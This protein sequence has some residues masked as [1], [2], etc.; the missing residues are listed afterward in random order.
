MSRSSGPT[1]S[2]VLRLLLTPRPRSGI[3]QSLQSH[4]DTDEVSR[5]KFDRLPRTAAGYTPNALDGYGLCGNPHARPAFRASY[6]VFVHRLARLLH[7]SFRP[8]LA[9]TPL[10]FATL[11]LHQVGGG[12]SPPA[13]EHARHTGFRSSLSLLPAIH[14]TEPLA[15]ALAGFLPAE[16]NCLIWTHNRT[17]GF[18]ASGSRTRNHALQHVSP[19]V[20]LEHLVGGYRLIATPQLFATSCDVP[21]LWPLPSAGVTRFHRYY[22]PIRHP[23]KRPSLSLAGCRLTVT[24]RHRWGFPCYARFPLHAC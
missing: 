16:H 10:R 1:P 12:L 21:E 20:A 14:A 19:P 7:A 11:H 22:G 13:I 6:P 5:G 23:R 17:C 4:R 8:H 2:C 15:F 3:S 18:I 9:V 24:C